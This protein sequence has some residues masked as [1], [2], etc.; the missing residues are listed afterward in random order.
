MRK[1]VILPFV[2]FACFLLSANLSHGAESCYELGY[3]YGLC[4]TQT[5]LGIRCKPENDIIIPQRCREKE[6]TNKGIKAGVKA[7]YDTLNIDQKG[8]SPTHR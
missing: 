4:A 7:V 2:I 3:R 6:E 5:M 1:L 8:S